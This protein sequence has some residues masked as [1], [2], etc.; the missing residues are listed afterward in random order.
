MRP[1]ALQ[2]PDR[3]RDQGRGVDG[4][5]VL[6]NT[7]E[8]GV[9]ERGGGGEGLGVPEPL[10]LGGEFGVL[11]ARG[12][13]ASISPSPKRSRSASWARSRARVVISSSSPV[14]ARSRR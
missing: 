12:A 8:R 7:R 11:P 9:R 3:A 10:R 13:T 2:G 6:G 4:L 5:G 1:Y 14:T